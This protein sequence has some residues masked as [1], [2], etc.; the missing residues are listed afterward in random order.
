MH[1]DVFLVFFTCATGG[2]M[3]TIYDQSITYIGY[4]DYR[5]GSK[6]DSQKHQRLIFRKK[7]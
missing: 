4:N 3:I 6:R 2:P 5:S 7:P 1:P